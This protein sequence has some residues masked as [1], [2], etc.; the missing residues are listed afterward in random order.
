MGSKRVPSVVD[1]ESRYTI[2]QETV[3]GTWWV[4]GDDRNYGPYLTKQ[5]AEQEAGWMYDH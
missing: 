3:T 4:E 1:P 2:V 5:E